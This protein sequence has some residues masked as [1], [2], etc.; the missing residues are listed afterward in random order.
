[1]LQNA[2]KSNKLLGQKRQWAYVNEVAS[3]LW[4]ELSQTDE[5]RSD[6]CV[7]LNLSGEEASHT[8]NL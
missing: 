4:D 7:W 2:L 5:V 6:Q 1:M 8:E 3:L